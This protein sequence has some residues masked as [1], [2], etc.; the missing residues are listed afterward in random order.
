MLPQIILKRKDTTLIMSQNKEIKT[1][2]L[3]AISSRVLQGS[4]FK[5]GRTW[6][7]DTTQQVVNITFQMMTTNQSNKALKF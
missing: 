4:P 5:Q 6:G 7:D 2:A 3:I 1:K